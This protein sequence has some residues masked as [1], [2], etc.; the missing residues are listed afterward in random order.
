MNFELRTLNFEPRIKAIRGAA[1]LF[2]VQR[3]M[4][5]VQIFPTINTQTGENK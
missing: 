3:S 5:R 1:F 4:F 2:R